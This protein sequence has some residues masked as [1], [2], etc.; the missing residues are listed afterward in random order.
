MRVLRCMWL[1]AVVALD[2]FSRSI[3]G[4]IVHL[5]YN[6]SQV[7]KKR[8][9]GTYICASHVTRHTCKWCFKGVDII[10]QC[11]RS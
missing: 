10:Q 3:Y 1:P 8:G 7:D 2:G 9:R 6:D 4:I 11:F 5:W